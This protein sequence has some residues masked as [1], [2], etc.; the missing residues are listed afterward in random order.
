[1]CCQIRNPTGPELP[2]SGVGWPLPVRERDSPAALSQ[3]AP[4]GPPP[5]R[6]PIPPTVSLRLQIGGGPVGQDA[7]DRG[8]YDCRAGGGLKVQIVDPRIDRL[9]IEKVL[10]ERALGL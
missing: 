8:D 5:S 6:R 1:M 9:K 2:G 4:N 3:D 7:D 10:K